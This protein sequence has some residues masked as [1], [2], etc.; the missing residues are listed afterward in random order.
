MLLVTVPSLISG[1]SIRHEDELKFIVAI[2]IH[3]AVAIY[4]RCASS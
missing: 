3:P 4:T 2:A 1:S